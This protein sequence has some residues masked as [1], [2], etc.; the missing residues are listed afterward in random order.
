MGFRGQ[1]ARH[2][3]RGVLLLADV[4]QQVYG[5][6]ESPRGIVQRGGKWHER[7]SRAIRPL[8]DC[9]MPPNGPALLQDYCHRTLVMRHQRAVQPIKSPR[10]TPL[11]AVKRRPSAPKRGSR[12]VE[13]RMYPLESVTYI[14][15]GSA[16]T[17]CQGAIP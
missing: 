12:V 5:A 9:L 4:N 7:H 16:S 6:D 2:F 3:C 8:G 15:A 11:I 14:A 17:S 1:F 13:I 10:P